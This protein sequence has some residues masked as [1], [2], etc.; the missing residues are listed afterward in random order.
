MVQYKNNNKQ[1]NSGERVE[2]RWKESQV[3]RNKKQYYSGFFSPYERIL[4]LV[5]CQPPALQTMRQV[6]IPEKHAEKA[7]IDV[8]CCQKQNKTKQKQNKNKTKTK[9]NETKRNIL[10]RERTLYGSMNKIS[11]I[12]MPSFCSSIKQDKLNMN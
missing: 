12:R 9:Q 5:A 3:L 11:L 10:T 4:A 2:I 6:Y 1:T 7:R 8:W